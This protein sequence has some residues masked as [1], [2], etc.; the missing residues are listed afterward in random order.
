M[1]LT[2]A[3]GG[4]SVQHREQKLQYTL[5]LRSSAHTVAQPRLPLL[6]PNRVHRTK[7]QDSAYHAEKTSREASVQAAAAGKPCPV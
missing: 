5:P 4:I 2:T 3:M 6:R 1:C 7:K